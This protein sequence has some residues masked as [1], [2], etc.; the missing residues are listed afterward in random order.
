MAHFPHILFAAKTDVGR[1]RKNNEDAY[2]VFHEAG[3]FCVADGMGGGDDGEVASAAT[4]RAVEQFVSSNPL[5][6]AAT[7]SIRDYTTALSRIINDASKWILDRAMEKGLKG[8]G[9]TFV[10]LCLDA[11]KPNEAVALH[12]GDSRLYRIRGR[13]VT[14]ITRDHSAA[15]LMG[16]RSEDEINPLFRGMILR[17]VGVQPTVELE[18]TAFD[19]RQDDKL[20][21]CSDGLYRMVPERKIV[22]T[23]RKSATPEEAAD[24]LIKIANEAG[25]VD[26]ITVVAVFIGELPPPMKMVGMDLEEAGTEERDTEPGCEEESGTDATD[27]DSQ[28]SASSLSERTAAT[29]SSLADSLRSVEPRVNPVCKPHIEIKRELSSLRRRNWSGVRWTVGS[30]VAA[31]LAVLAG[32]YMAIKEEREKNNIIVE[33]STAIVSLGTNGCDAVNI[34]ATSDVHVVSAIRPDGKGRGE[35]HSEDVNNKSVPTPIAATSRSATKHSLQDADSIPH[36]VVMTL[37]MLEEGVTCVFGGSNIVGSVR[38]HPGV[39]YS[40]VYKRVGYKSQDIS[41]DVKFNE[42]GM[43]PAPDEWEALLVEVLI[44][45]FGDDVKCR[46]DGQ[47]KT[48]GDK[49]ELRPGRHSLEYSRFGYHAKAEE[50]E[51]KPGIPKRLAPPSKWEVLPVAMA[52]PHLPSGVRCKINGQERTS[53]E[54]IELRP[55][56]Y[57]LEYSRLGYEAQTSEVVVEL[58]RPETILPPREWKALPVEIEVPMLPD[59][60]TCRIDGQEKLP[61]K[62]IELEPG[63]HSIVYSMLDYGPQEFMFSVCPAKR[64]VLPS[65]TAWNRSDG[66]VA[67]ENAEN[68]I[69]KGQWEEARKYLRK[70]RVESEAAR[71]KRQDIVRRLTDYDN[72]MADEKARRS[73]S[74]EGLRAVCRDMSKCVE[75]AML[76][77]VEE[78]ECAKMCKCARLLQEPGSEQNVDEQIEGVVD[79]FRANCRIETG[80]IWYYNATCLGDLTPGN[81]GGVGNKDSRRAKMRGACLLL[82]EK[83]KKLSQTT[84]NSLDEINA[85]VDII[86][87]MPFW[88]DARNNH[89]AKR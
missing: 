76:C 5:P 32:W 1:K 15:E 57:S 58:G 26:N 82:E 36:E 53:D 29:G 35:G 48:S 21:I 52:V 14:Q 6:E 81:L 12:A 74:V 22:S 59:G 67:L 55:G 13:S 33:E 56:K 45:N 10:S 65:L 8:C 68:A 24:E 11:S 43:I 44:P 34:G 41:F 73:K 64:V 40:C 84:P 69:G 66:L 77:G 39:G 25:G 19:I 70:A 9:S 4:I 51:V 62:R 63:E 46:V 50:F 28:D 89:N 20:L 42:D 31:V 87:Y 16:A 17:A 23:M 27:P 37:P 49:I 60:V 71:N 85:V 78:E 88:L 18:S 7:Y 83:F 3:L 38:L 75:V 80:T 30:I 54:K 72:K 47:E 2:G 61:G 79:F 86:K